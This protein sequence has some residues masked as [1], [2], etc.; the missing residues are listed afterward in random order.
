MGQKINPLGFRLP[1]NKDWHSRWFAKDPVVYRKNLLEDVKIR[2]FLMKKLELAGI[3]RVQIERSI[4][5]VKITLFVSRPGVVIG[6]GGSGLELL[7]KGL[8]KLVSIPEPEKN[9]ELDVAEIKNSELSA[10][11]VGIRTAEQ[12]EKRMPHRRVVNKTIERVMGAG[13]TGVKILLSG[14]IGGAEIGRRETY[15][16]GSLPLHTLRAK[17]DYAQTPALTKSGYVGIKVWIYTGEED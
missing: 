7:K 2:K 4:N 12:L 3:V 1:Q 14:R 11:L 10:R 6:R 8:I 17:I 16:K 13:A 9:L 5:R 15:Q